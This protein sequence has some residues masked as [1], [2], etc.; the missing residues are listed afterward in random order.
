MTNPYP[1]IQ[2]SYVTISDNLWYFIL[3]ELKLSQFYN[4]LW[5]IPMTHSKFIVFIV[6]PFIFAML[7]SHLTRLSNKFVFYATHFFYFH[8][9]GHL[10]STWVFKEST[11]VFKEK[12]DQKSGSF[13]TFDSY[14]MTHDRNNWKIN[15]IVL[16]VHSGY[17]NRQRNLLEIVCWHLKGEMGHQRGHQRGHQKVSGSN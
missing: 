14:D 2:P 16:P 10:W 8:S 9:L 1:G 4:L 17:T 5:L 13:I 12:V 7:A 3:Y 15:K 6:E 11:R